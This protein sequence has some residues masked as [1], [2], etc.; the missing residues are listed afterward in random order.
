MLRIIEIFA[1]KKLQ[2]GL[3]TLE[4]LYYILSADGISWD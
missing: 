4:L 1:R 3:A 2:H